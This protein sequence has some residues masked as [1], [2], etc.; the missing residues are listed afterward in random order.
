MAAVASGLV[1]AS[2]PQPVASAHIVTLSMGGLA[3]SP[4]EPG[5][6]QMSRYLPVEE[7]A[8]TGCN[9]TGT[10]AYER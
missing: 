6:L 9:A 4:A 1:K 7:V 3:H 10:Q 5:P 8:S 2:M